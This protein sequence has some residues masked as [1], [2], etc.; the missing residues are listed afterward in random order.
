[1]NDKRAVLFRETPLE[2]C[3]RWILGTAWALRPKRIGALVPLTRAYIAHLTGKNRGLPD[4]AALGGT[5]E[6]AGVADD[7]SPP[8]LMKA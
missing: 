5:C 4:A 8:T 6:L 2:T 7:L 1:M 3:E